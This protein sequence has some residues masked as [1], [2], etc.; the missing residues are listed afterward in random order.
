MIGLAALTAFCFS[1]PLGKPIFFELGVGA[2]GFGSGFFAAGTLTAAMEVAK[3]AQAGLALGAWGA[4]GASATG[5]GIALGGALRD[6]MA[7]LAAQGRFGPALIGAD[8]GYLI[9]Y[10]VEIALLFATLAAIGPLVRPAGDASRQ[11]PAISALPIFQV[12]KTLEV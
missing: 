3:T 6:V 8:T 12:N 5:A 11:T 7:D 1:A 10:H 9:V 4:V 2:L